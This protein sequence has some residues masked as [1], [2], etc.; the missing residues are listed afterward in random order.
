MKKLIKIIAVILPLLLA[1]SFILL[2]NTVD[3]PVNSTSDTVM[4]VHY[5]DVGQGDS[6]LIESNGSYMLIDAGKANKSETII[7]YLKYIGVKKLDYVI[8]TH[9]DADHIGGAAD[10]IES[11]S[12]GKVIMPGKTHTTDTFENLLSA[13]KKKGLKITRP[14]F[15]NKYTVGMSSFT[16]IAPNK[17]YEDNNNSSAGLK[18]VNGDTSFL[19]IGDAE[20]EAIDDI[21]AN[22]L[23]LKADVLM[24][25]HHGSDTSTTKEFLNAVDPDSAVISVGKDNSYGHPADTTLKLFRDNKIKLYRTDENG[26]IVA[27]SNGKTVTFTATA[28]DFKSS[29]NTDGSIVYITETGKKYHVA[30]CPYLSQ[31]KIKTTLKEAKDEGLSPCSKCNPPE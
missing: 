9:P 19:F 28:Y 25:G 15:G 30:D 10:V 3:T 7:N 16:I 11:F 12:I 20:K 13:I 23:D 24:A 5:I 2:H 8:W 29:A 31:G 6:V 14:E 26:T 17:E 22:G 18:L 4:K 21:M 27:S 1:A